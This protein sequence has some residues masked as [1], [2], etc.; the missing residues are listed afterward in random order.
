MMRAL[1]EPNRLRLFRALQLK[2][3]CVSDLVN[4]EGLPQP[5][6]SHH[7]SVLVR[8]GLVRARRQHGFTLYAIDP[9]GVDAARTTIA[10]LLDTEA[11]Q[12]AALPGGNPWCCREGSC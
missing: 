12:P 8:A 7:L 3:R 2:E 9:S 6:V 11:L 4:Q 10:D 1:G 5:L